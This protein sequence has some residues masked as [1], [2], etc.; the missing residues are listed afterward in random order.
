VKHTNNTLVYSLAMS[1]ALAFGPASRAASD[2]DQQRQEAEQQARPEVQKEKNEAEQKAEKTLDQEAIAAIGETTNAIKSIADNKTDEALAAIERATGKINILLAR[3]PATALLPVSV[4]VEIIEA[5]PL[6]LEAIKVVAKEAERAVDD[7][8]YPAARVLLDSLT[9][10]IRVRTTNLPLASYPAAL[11]EAARLL[12]EKKS[13]EANSV[14]LAELNT[15]AIV[16]TVAPLPLVLAQTAINEA[17]A[18]REKD[19][20]AAQKQLAAARNELER[21][22]ALGYAGKDG[23]Y[24][25]LNKDIKDL[26]KQLKSNEDTGSLFASLKDKVSALFKRQSEDKQPQSESKK[27]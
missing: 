8:A 16:D 23:T 12:D 26:E 14:L 15:L 11:K 7:K 1:L 20:E 10:E 5:A 24:A 4:R 2:I 17:Q 13:K 22:R 25:A 21:A 6:D 19:K 3:N 27:P 9:S 18:L